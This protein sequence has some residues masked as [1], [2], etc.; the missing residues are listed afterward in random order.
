VSH[1][2]TEVSTMKSSDSSF[3]NAAMS[4][5][6]PK[7]S[8]ADRPSGAWAKS[9][10]VAVDVASR[11]SKGRGRKKGSPEDQ[12]DELDNQL[13]AAVDPAMQSNGS[14]PSE[15][16]TSSSASTPTST[17]SEG[18]RRTTGYSSNNSTN[19][20]AASN[21]TYEDRA[22]GMWAK[23]EHSNSSGWG[24]SSLYGLLGGGLALGLSAGGGGG[25]SNATGAQP[26]D[27][28]TTTTTVSIH[29][30]ESVGIDGA[31]VFAVNADESLT[32]LGTTD[33]S[34]H[35]SVNSSKITSGLVVKSANLPDLKAITTPGSTEKVLVV[36][37]VTT[38]VAALQAADSR[39]RPEDAETLVKTSLGLDEEIN[40]KTYDPLAASEIA[41]PE[42]LQLVKTQAAL[43]TIL[44]DQAIGPDFMGQLAQYIAD[45]QEE[46]AVIDLSSA[47]KLELIIGSPSSSELLEINNV[48]DDNAQLLQQTSIKG[49]QDAFNVGLTPV[50]VGLKND[51]GESDTDKKTIDPDLVVSG[52]KIGAS[53]EFTLDGKTWTKTL[54]D[55]PAGPL[56]IQARLVYG[57]NKYSALSEPFAFEYL[58]PLQPPAPSLTLAEDTGVSD[59][60]GVTSNGELVLGNLQSDTFVEYSLDNKTWQTSFTPSADGVYKVYVRQTIIGKSADEASPSKLLEF[61][62]DTVAKVG[63]AGL[64]ANIVDESEND[65]GGTDIDGNNIAATFTDGITSDTTPILAGK[66]EAGASSVTVE[67]GGRTYQVAQS[68][69]LPDGSW[70]LQLPQALPE[71]SYKPKV[72]VVDQAGNTSRVELTAFTIDT[73][74]PEAPEEGVITAAL[75]AATDTYLPGDGITNIDRPVLT[76]TTEPNAHVFVDFDGQSYSAISD[77]DGQWTVTVNN[78]LDEGEYATL[79]KVVD[80]AGNETEFD[81]PVITV[82][83][84]PPELDTQAHLLDEEEVDTGLNAD[85]GITNNNLP[86]IVGSVEEGTFVS[87][88]LNGKIY[89]VAAVDGDWSFKVPEDEELDDGT[90][91]VNIVYSDAAGNTVGEQSVPFT[92]DTE[93]AS[94]DEF[95]L[96]REDDNDTGIYSDDGITNNDSPLFRGIV[97]LR[98][99]GTVEPGL[100]VRITIGDNVYETEDGDIAEDGSWELTA[101]G[102]DDGEYEAIIQVVDLAGNVSDEETVTLIV[103]TEEPESTAELIHDEENDTG[104]DTEDNIT[105]NT[106]PMISGETEPLALVEVEVDG[107]FYEVEADDDGYWEI[108]LDELAAGEYTPVII[109]TD[110]AGNVFEGEGTTFEVTD[111]PDLTVGTAEFVFD[112]DNDTGI[113]PEDGITKNNS[114]TF[115][116]TGSPGAI[117][118]MDFDGDVFEAVVDENGE[119]TLTADNLADGEYTPVITMADEDGNEGDPLDIEITITIDTEAPSSADPAAELVHDED[120]DSGEDTED[121]ITNI[122]TPTLFGDI[123]D[124]PNATL[125]LI[126]R[127]TTTDEEFEIPDVEVDEDGHWEFTVDS[128]LTDGDYEVAIIVTDVAGNVSDEIEGTPFTVVTSVELTDVVTG[129]L[130]HDADNDTGIDEFDSITQNDSPVLEGTGGVPGLIVR[131]ELDG[132]FFEG[133]VADDGTWTVETS[134]LVDGEYTPIITFLDI[135]GNESE[136]TNGDVFTVDTEA[137]DEGDITAA[138]TTG[139]DNDTGLADDDGVTQ[140]R[141][142][143]MSGTAESFAQIMVDIGVG[144]PYFTEADEFGDW[145]IALDELDDGEYL[146]IITV[147]DAAGNET[148]VEGT[149]FTIDSEAPSSAD[150]A[151]ELVH[152]EDSDSGE[153]TEDNI[154][155]IT[156]PTLF[157]DI[158]DAPNATLTL[159][160]RNTTTDE[161]FEIPDVEVDED[162]HWEYT[163]DSELTDGDYEVAIIVTDA[164]GNES[165][166]I[167]GTPFTV[168]TQIEVS[169]LA[170]GGLVHDADNDTGL[171]DFDNFTQNDSPTL[172]GTGGV[173]G[174]IVRVELD[175]EFFEGEVAADGTWTVETSGLSD[176]EYT[177]IITFLDIAGNESE[178]TEGTPFTIDTQAPDEGE[179]ALAIESD[180]GA[181]NDDGITSISA[182]I[183]RGTAEPG[184]QISVDIGVGDPYLTEADLNGDWEI[185]LD[186]LEDGEE[187]LPTITVTDAAGNETEFDGTPFTIDTEAPSSADPAAELD[188]D[189]G[190]DSGEDTEDN[191]TNITKPTLFGDI[192]D[193]PNATLTLILRNTTTDV[194][195]KINGIEVDE[196]GH[197]E[198]TVANNLPDGDYELAIIVTDAAGNE[199]LEIEGTPFTVDHTAPVPG[200]G[201]LLHDEDNDTGTSSDD[202]YTGNASPVLVG[203]AE[204]GATVKV[205]INGKV[206]ETVADGGE[207]EVSFSDLPDGTYT[208]IISVTDVA[209]NVTVSQGTNFV[210]DTTL[211]NASGVTGGLLHTASN[212]TGASAFDSIT[213]NS[214]PILQGTA[215]ALADVLVVVD[216]EEYRTNANINGVWQ[217]QLLELGDDTYIPEITVIDKAGNQ[218]DLVFGTPFTIVT[219]TSGDASGELV[220]DTANDTGAEIDDGI[221]RNARPMLVGEADAG[222]TVFIDLDNGTLPM[223]TF[224]VQATTAGTWSLQVPTALPDGTYTPRVYVTDLAGNTSEPVEGEPIVIDTQ[225][226]TASGGLTHDDTNDTG[227]LFT[228][229]I[230]N[231][232]LPNL[233]GRAESGA[234]V[235]VTLGSLVLEEVQ[236]DDD[237]LWSVDVSEEL[238]NGRYTP[239]IKVTDLAGNTATFAGEAFTVKLAAETDGINIGTHHVFV[240]GRSVSIDLGTGSFVDYGG[241]LPKG[242]TL[243]KSTGVI[244]GIATE[245]GFTWIATTLQDAAGNES[246]VYSQIAVVA[247]ERQTATN[248]NSTINHSGYPDAVLFTGSSVRNSIGMSKS[249]GDVVLAGD[250][251]DTVSVADTRNISP[252]DGEGSPLDF[253]RLDGG[254]GIDT[255][256]FSGLGLQLDFSNFNSPDGEGK[257]LQRFE[258]VALASK[259]MEVTIT[260]GDLFRMKSDVFD[261]DG[262][263]HMVRFNSTSTSGSTIILDGFEQVGGDYKFDATGALGTSKT[264]QEYS[265]YTGIYED[266]EGQHLLTLLFSKGITAA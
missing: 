196:D 40:L 107:V 265:K 96:V 261:V 99:D 57:D 147:T 205:T 184:A 251:D 247:T 230:T 168:I 69:L 169:G 238:P 244:S 111:G 141:N 133:E 93:A 22:A 52:L 162:G 240:K 29:V 123:E 60:D 152:D 90:Y 130:V 177:P 74:D 200:T 188:H 71:G 194:E 226:P 47:D 156:T 163:V 79:I 142:P 21:N 88:I 160:L 167:E 63:T 151:A 127:N 211:P 250:G 72:T 154:T 16:S 65:T 81:G 50:I 28:E 131:V 248:A 195:I 119:W 17:E 92:I 193:A 118:R 12:Q 159:I 235:T 140:V 157:G 97:T 100:I 8:E 148:E 263:S 104:E 217:V 95:D 209:G 172:E 175:G 135:A 115:I 166:E 132:E 257:V 241:T 138:L 228:D 85:D 15:S 122:T 86:T 264:N 67:V 46:P 126:L 233:S 101:D 153:D 14:T 144:D 89:A 11:A 80:G 53:I 124:A 262:V 176:N 34:G 252:G 1:Q 20:A 36:N 158:E 203:T 94:F 249:Y 161:E 145:E 51:T 190:S 255:V 183:L 179:A 232:N 114:P 231:N 234:F 59:A 212:D 23:H 198:H 77:E 227:I 9:D 108:Q 170:T 31:K 117:V 56:S 2:A 204:D 39:L 18:D 13:L 25:K 143:L 87:A 192:E 55:A 109:V 125:T 242:L 35:L 4:A 223:R 197:W 129:N 174:L 165:D 75:T 215:P 146:P 54:D 121:N 33:A 243:N 224:T 207:W 186:A 82:D 44:G 187:Y 180:T 66:T 199:G 27:G 171:V 245:S 106:A 45:R 98:D 6:A 48:A 237:G 191:I 30:G 103:D 219:E 206:E 229:G 259:E 222:A 7:L 182:P 239:S 105:S 78:P 24:D 137:P 150:P 246:T 68:D 58:K 258:E 102:L 254:R 83:L 149:P 49:V 178:P 202:N 220:H 218:S 253:A 120:S 155:N 256:K 10:A 64:A 139:E 173:P 128:E 62:L 3:T 37:P 225:V 136:P 201:G 214:A 216:G 41:N 221:T 213:K 84:T 112:E 110:L 91:T 185:Q 260:A 43:S 208:P 73:T 26:T 236:A 38:L 61:K 266:A 19:V 181:L 113:D 32:F 189:G 5:S 210:V 164:A 76:G 134:G 42:A 70:T 116:G